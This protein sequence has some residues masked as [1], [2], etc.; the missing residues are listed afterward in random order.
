MSF[1]W[2]T[3][4]SATDL[5]VTSTA[6]QHEPELPGH[7]VALAEPDP[8]LASVYFT[9]D[10]A[11]NLADAVV[12][13]SSGALELSGGLSGNLSAALSAVADLSAALSQ[14]VN[15]V[16]AAFSATISGVV[17][18]DAE[19]SA[20]FSSTIADLSSAFS[21]TVSGVYD[22]MT[23]MSSAFSATIGVISGTVF[24]TSGTSGSW[25]FTPGYADLYY[26]GTAA[27]VQLGTAWGSWS[28]WQDSMSDPGNNI[29]PDPGSGKLTL[30]VPGI[31]RVHAQAS[32]KTN[33][34]QDV[35]LSIFQ[36]GSQNPKL[37]ARASSDAGSVR[38]ISVAG[39]VSA[40]V[41]GNDIQMQFKAASGTPTFTAYFIEFDATRVA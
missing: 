32:W 22:A 28:Q 18:N 19:V 12:A 6:Q 25:P 39:L 10:D 27:S 9:I 30:Q 11:N 13:L 36:T 29:V 24:H 37:T 35:F 16:S 26:S 3:Q 1:N 23:D 5:Y 4:I 20:A 40:S 8:S 21:S 14:T 15:D 31:Y 38:M 41:A 7:K 33:G 2:Q 34:A 17:A